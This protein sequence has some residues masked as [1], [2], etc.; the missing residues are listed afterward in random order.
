MGQPRL[1][2]ARGIWCG[3][4]TSLPRE[5][6]KYLYLI[7]S[8][9]VKQNSTSEWSSVPTE[10]HFHSVKLISN[11]SSSKSSKG[12]KTLI[13]PGSSLCRDELSIG[14]AEHHWVPPPAL[15]PTGPWKGLHFQVF[16]QSSSFQRQSMFCVIPVPAQPSHHPGCR[17]PRPL[18]GRELPKGA[19]QHCRW[20]SRRSHSACCIS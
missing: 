20:G 18:R 5:E 4:G 12:R 2:L 17:F 10:L 19:L 3:T 13:V 6:G 14:T 7:F 9:S 8:G 1:F 11:S 16:L 15:S